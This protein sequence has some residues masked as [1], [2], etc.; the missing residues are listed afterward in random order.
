MVISLFLFPNQYD[1]DVDRMILFKNIGSEEI[2][3]P[4]TMILPVVLYGV[5][6]F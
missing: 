5:K 2:R 6:R 1:F 3:I 4:E